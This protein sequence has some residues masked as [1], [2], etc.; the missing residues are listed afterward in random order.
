MYRYFGI[1]YLFVVGALIA[2]KLAGA[3]HWAWWVVLLP[4]WSPILIAFIAVLIMVI[5]FTSAE[6]RGENPFQ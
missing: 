5:G 3:L 6:S 4:I 1:L 2:A